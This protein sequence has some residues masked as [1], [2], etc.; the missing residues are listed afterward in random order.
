[1]QSY[2]KFWSEEKKQVAERCEDKNCT[3]FYDNLQEMYFIIKKFEDGS[4]LHTKETELF[5]SYNISEI[6]TFIKSVN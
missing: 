4:I 1:M 3:L 2:N 6:N 5:K